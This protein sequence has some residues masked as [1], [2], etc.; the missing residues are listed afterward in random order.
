[1]SYSV[2]VE[3]PLDADLDRAGETVELEVDSDETILR[4]GRKAGVWLPADCQQGWCTTCA[5]HLLEGEVDQSTAKYRFA[6][7]ED[8][9]FVLTCVARPRSDCRIEACK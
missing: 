1:M 3:I 4:A 8:A 7:D 2:E 5:A 6:V 9:G